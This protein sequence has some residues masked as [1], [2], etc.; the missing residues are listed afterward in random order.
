MEKGSKN[1]NKQRLKV[2]KLYEYISNQRK[3]Y[4]HKESRKIANKYDCVCIEDLNMQGMSQCLNFGKSVSDNGWGMFTTFL[5]YK[6]TEQG[7]KLIKVGKFFPSSQ[8]CNVCGSINQI[9]KDLSVREW[10]CPN[11][12]THHNRDIN[13]AINIKNQGIQLA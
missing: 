4:L 10:A 7:K 8:T 2:A 1:R 11:C 3:D 5:A 9:T 12:N 6:L 13:A